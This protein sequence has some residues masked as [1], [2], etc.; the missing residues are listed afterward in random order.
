MKQIIVLALCACLIAPVV[1][2]GVMDDVDQAVVDITAD[3]GMIGAWVSRAL[4]EGLAQAAAG[5]VSMPASVVRLTGVEIGVA[6]GVE[7]W[8]IDRPSFRR[9]ATRTLV[10]LPVGGINLPNS[11]LMPTGVLQVKT[12]LPGGFD[13]G[14]KYGAVSYSYTD[15]ATDFTAENSIYGVELRY[16]LAGRGE[17]TGLLTPDVAL[18]ASIDGAHGSFEKTESYAQT[19]TEVYDDA[20]YTQQ[21]QSRAIWKTDWHV[22]RAELAMVVSK[23][24]V[25]ITP[26]AGAAIGRN[27]GE[28]ATTIAAAGT[29]SL[30]PA[31]G[32]ARSKT[33][34][35]RSTQKDR[36]ERT[37]P[38]F[39]GGVEMNLLL[40]HL[41]ASGSWSSEARSAYL[42]ARFQF[43]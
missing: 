29:V 12:G 23:S 43:R 34:A 27:F 21:V 35:I 26:Y 1:E 42:I 32:P 6:A 10:V 41:G 38:R 30:D 5:G 11:F 15:G 39:F 8:A 17:L 36:A 28:A 18:C 13:I 14:A 20:S 16:H 2:A 4:S 40:F 9:L 7:T 3:Y 22:G 31:L 25:L 33:F 19:T 37:L 24:L